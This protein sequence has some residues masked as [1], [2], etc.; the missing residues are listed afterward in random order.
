L[1]ESSSKPPSR[2]RTAPQIQTNEQPKTESNSKSAG[3]FQP[4]LQSVDKNIEKESLN[5]KPNVSQSTKID[6]QRDVQILTL[7][8]DDDKNQSQQITNEENQQIP[9]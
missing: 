9:F 8:D 7:D 6:I 4:N 2:P 5:T 1:I 3:L